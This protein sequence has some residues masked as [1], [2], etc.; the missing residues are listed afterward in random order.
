MKIYACAVSATIIN[1]TSIQTEIFP[2]AT[3]AENRQ[4]ATGKA[5]EAGYKQ[6]PK[7]EGYYN[8]QASVVEIPEQ[9]I[10]NND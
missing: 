7:T 1:D 8:H 2:M 3:K 6:L 10:V 5:I 9:W 4:E